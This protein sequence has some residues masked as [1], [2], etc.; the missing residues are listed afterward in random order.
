VALPPLLPGVSGAVGLVLRLRLVAIGLASLNAR[1][2]R[3]RGIVHGH[4]YS[5]LLYRYQSSRIRSYIPGNAARI[6]GRR[7]SFEFRAPLTLSMAFSPLSPA[8]SMKPSILSLPCS[9]LCLISPPRRS[10]LPSDSSFLASRDSS[11]G[12][13]RPPLHL[14]SLS[15]HR[16][17]FS[18]SSNV[19]PQG[20]RSLPARRD[21]RRGAGS[22][23]RRAGRE[24]E[25]GRLRLVL[26]RREQRTDAD[27]V[28]EP[29]T[30]DPCWP[31][32]RCR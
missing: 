17:P 18:L 19:S 21:Q 14:I 12:L 23:D 30:S 20:F 8:L 3:P 1:T 22:I 11:C 32:T 4:S 10:A 2:S 25:K 16:A 6:L 26:L 9:R 13:L 29:A 5:L 15:T 24:P 27:M 28:H 31:K 7:G